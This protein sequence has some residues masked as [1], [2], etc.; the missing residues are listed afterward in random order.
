MKHLL[1]TA[2]LA[3]LALASSTGFAAQ[4]DANLLRGYGTDMGRAQRCGVAFSGVLL[5]SQLI[6]DLTQLGAD[7]QA[8]SAAFSSAAAAARDGALPDCTAAS[9]RFDAATLE[10]YKHNGRQP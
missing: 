10:L 9:A 5:F 7:P 8:L 1:P 4:P 3:F 2:L 6:K